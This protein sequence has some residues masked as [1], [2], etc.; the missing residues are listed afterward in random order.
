MFIAIHFLA[1]TTPLRFDANVFFLG[2]YV[3]VFEEEVK[4]HADIA[5]QK[6]QEGY[7]DWQNVGYPSYVC[8]GKAGNCVHEQ[9]SRKLV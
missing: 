4:V 8:W 5:T 1:A 2:R 7:V 6:S 9:N 3:S